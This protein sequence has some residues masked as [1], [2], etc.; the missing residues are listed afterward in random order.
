MKLQPA[1]DVILT[2]G[3]ITVRLAPSFRAAIILEQR[4]GGYVAPLSDLSTFKLATVYA[5]IRAAAID[6]D[7][8]NRLIGAL[9]ALPLVTVQKITLH[10]LVTLISRLMNVGEDDAQPEHNSTSE[11]YSV[12][13]ATQPRECADLLSMTATRNRTLK[14]TCPVF[15]PPHV[16]V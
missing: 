3:D 4:Q 11:C 1:Y 13:K 8:A 15:V 2:H 9:G 7:A 14:W 10:A 5:V 12:S 6:V 16:L